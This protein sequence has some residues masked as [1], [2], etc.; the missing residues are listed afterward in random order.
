MWRILLCNRDTYYPPSLVDSDH[1]RFTQCLGPSEKPEGF[2]RIITG[3]CQVAIFL[4]TVSSEFILH[5]KQNICHFGN[6]K[7]AM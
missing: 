4:G 6:A 3:R 5:P 2:I 7:T 1:I